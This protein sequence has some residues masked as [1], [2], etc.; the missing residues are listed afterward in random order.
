MDSD[1]HRY[2]PASIRYRAFFDELNGTFAERADVLRQISLALLAREHVLLAGPP[3]TAK[4]QLA[5]AVFARILDETTGQ[6]SLYS[7]QIG[8]S[9]VRT[10]LV[11][12][13]DFKTLMATGRSEHFTDEGML[14]AVHAFLDEIFDGRD[15]LLRD[16]LNVLQE[17]ELKQGTKVV[18]GQIECALMTSNR[19]LVEVLEDSRET[20][21]AF[22]DRIAFAGFVPR[23]FAGDD[24]LSSVL[25]RQ[26]GGSGR[27]S[28]LAKLSVQDVD[29]LQEA[30]GSV[31]VPDEICERLALL[32]VRFDEEVLKATRADPS[33]I[34]TRYVS[35]RTAVRA[36][37][38][39]R[40]IA[41]HRSI[42][43]PRA[44]QRV[45]EADDLRMLYLHL[46]LSGPA[47]EVVDRLIENER[48][49]RE[50]RQ[51]KILQTERMLFDRAF[52]SLPAPNPAP[53]RR[54]E[55]PTPS[56]SVPS[57]E[58]APSSKASAQ[59]A[60]SLA[61]SSPSVV[62]E[63]IK[64]IVNAARERRISEREAEELLTRARS[65]L[66]AIAVA[67]ALSPKDGGSSSPEA[68]A[69]TLASF[70]DSLEVLGVP[71]RPIARYL[72][73]RAIA[74]L[75]E[76][77]RVAPLPGGADPFGLSNESPAALERARERL[78]ALT[79]RA[80]RRERLLA[81]GADGV[82]ATEAAWKTTVDRAEQEL[83]VL[84]DDATSNRIANT[85]RG[86]IDDVTIIM[87]ALKP[88]LTE[89]AMV[90]KRLTD[91][92]GGARFR[93]RVVGKRMR[94]ILSAAFAK[95][96]VD[97]RK[98]AVDKIGALQRLMLEAEVADTVSPEDWVRWTADVL[99]ATERVASPPSDLPPSAEAYAAL[100]EGE[101]RRSN[102]VTLADVV[103]RS[104]PDLVLGNATPGEAESR[105]VEVLATLPPGTREKIVAADVAR[106]DRA[107]SL[108][109]EWWTRLRPDDASV[110][111]IRHSNFVRVV[112][113]DG[114]LLRFALEAR[115]LAKLFG[116]DAADAERLV[117]R[118]ESLHESV[119]S[120]VDAF[121]RERADLAW[122]DVLDR[123]KQP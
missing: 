32:L 27:A 73:G 10:D 29:A 59:L 74:V 12:P 104:A 75:D 21:L 79:A 7:R 57:P 103:L 43:E 71:G 39:L 111:D 77:Y 67:T 98:V 91:L 115:T 87:S 78:A 34:P 8:E 117:A 70:A 14:G 114:A 60:L 30:T 119:R 53:T 102:A 52:D 109:S 42:F 55:T 16:A 108:L 120:R 99:L 33:F 96:V 106:I 15:M 88:A 105:V 89:L 41:I 64:S 113:E 23:G 69:E 6:A 48:D 85:F 101:H 122:S 20:L 31:V 100:R 3:G 24:T 76:S 65:L 18:K 38:I 47:I 26:V 2:E 49:P 84:W 35:T 19:Y 44:R 123:S 97:D 116:P 110:S 45:V 22:V 1:A 54:P 25:K 82:E 121:A 92:G 83:V 46:T 80:K 50:R 62:L 63:G 93:S 112:W 28:L 13:V 58:T 94:S 17:R 9:T 61:S 36:G 5:S 4:S 56:P 68:V 90:E 37:E 107:L 81:K 11:G 86:G 95:L 66:V 118:A 72:R 51:L 40:A